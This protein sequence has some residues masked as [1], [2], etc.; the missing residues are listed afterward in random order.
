VSAVQTSVRQ[1]ASCQLDIDLQS[2]STSGFGAS[3][4]S[5]AE[6]SESSSMALDLPLGLVVGRCAKSSED[7]SLEDGSG[8]SGIRL[9]E[10]C[11]LT[12]RACFAV[13]QRS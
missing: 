5:S 1:S 9:F 6:L 3:P 4:I 8:S 7:S 13:A 11:E 12:A 10:G 2:G